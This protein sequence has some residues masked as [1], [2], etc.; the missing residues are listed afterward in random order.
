MFGW[1]KKSGSGDRDPEQ[2]G[3]RQ[4]ITLF[5][6]AER[7]DREDN[8]HWPLPR[9]DHEL[10]STVVGVR[11]DNDDGTSRQRI[12]EEG[13]RAGDTLGYRIE[14]ENARYPS[15][16]AVLTPDGRQ[17]GH[18]HSGL[19]TDVRRWLADGHLVRL[20]ANQ[21]IYQ[22]EETPRRAVRILVQ[23]YHPSPEEQEQRLCLEAK[24]LESSIKD[25]GHFNAANVG[26]LMTIL[27]QERRHS[28]GKLA[29]SALEYG[30]PNYTFL[31]AQEKK[32]LGLN[33]RKT[34]TRELVS[35]FNP[36][37]LGVMEPKSLLYDLKAGAF[38][39]TARTFSLAKMRKLGFI[40]RVSVQCSDGCAAIQ[41]AERTFTISGAPAL[42]LAECDRTC[43]C[44]YAPVMD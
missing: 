44:T 4:R 10:R 13:V 43:A 11:F 28:Y 22:P 1:L 23:I 15:A 30:G 38:Y 31:T 3:I 41:R 7:T 34:Y 40:K 42:P 8:T 29:H 20:T 24:I 27:S 6:D 35:F 36:K 21:I 14:G 9:G 2:S 25:S 33:T 26:P 19:A 39:R 12:I 17:I 5:P 37:S 16:V 32:A 18:L